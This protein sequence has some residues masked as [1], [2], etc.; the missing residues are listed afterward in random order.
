MHRTITRILVVVALLV[1]LLGIRQVSAADTV[2]F[3]NVS[4]V[5]GYV[6]QYEEYHIQFLLDREVKAEETLS[7]VFDDNINL[8]LYYNIAAGDMTLDGIP[9][10]DSA[11]W[12]GHILTVHT[13][14]VLSAGTVHELTIL[15]SAMVQ[16]P[17]TPIH[18]QLTEG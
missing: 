4:I 9:A 1:S 8:A 11:H 12:S 2:P 13:P 10:G 7:I 5:E 18:V 17:Q 15:R 16:N 14:T 6:G 3:V